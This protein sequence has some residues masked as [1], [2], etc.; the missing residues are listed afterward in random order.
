[1]EQKRFNL[2][3]PKLSK[4]DLIVIAGAG[5]FIGGSLVKYFHDNGFTR[6]R[7]AV[8]KPLDEGTRSLGSRDLQL[9]CSNERH[10][11]ACQKAVEVHNRATIWAVWLDERFRV[12]AAK[13]PHQYPYDRRAYRAGAKRYFFSR[14]PPVPNTLLQQDP[15][16]TALKE[17]DAIRDGRARRGK[18]SSLKCSARST[19]PNG[20]SRHSSP[21]STMPMA[22]T[23]LTVTRAPAANRRKVVEATTVAR[24]IEI[25]ETAIRPSSCTSTTVSPASHDHALRPA[26]LPRRSILPERA[27]VHQRA[28]KQRRESQVS[29]SRANTTSRSTRRRRP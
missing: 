19:G 9:D 20:A 21:A 10:A 5:G 2:K 24:K 25:W 27:G 18:S 16:V 11:S 12:E 23:A 7:A 4:E 15:N 6:I 13:H 8:K 22:P 17:S 3:E 26:D 29:R 1:M 14:P 28:C